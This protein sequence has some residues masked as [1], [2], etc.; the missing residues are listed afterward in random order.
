M[1]DNTYYFYTFIS[2]FKRQDLRNTTPDILELNEIPKPIVLF[3]DMQ[4]HAKDW[5]LM[6]MTA[7]E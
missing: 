6:R 5:L 7:A 2:H 4:N 3:G 1:K